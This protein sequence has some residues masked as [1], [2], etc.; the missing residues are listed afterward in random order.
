MRQDI[1]K[2]QSL[3]MKVVTPPNPRP[4]PNPKPR[5]ICTSEP[6]LFMNSSENFKLPPAFEKNMT[7]HYSHR[8][9]AKVPQKLYFY[10]KAQNM[11]Q[12][13]ISSALGSHDITVEYLQII[14]REVHLSNKKN[15]SSFQKVENQQRVLFKQ[16]LRLFVKVE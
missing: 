15:K 9:I 10:T 11:Q 5:I 6:S 2:S 7:S 4:N 12:M 14:C 1:S 16:L 8:K 3:P 13:T